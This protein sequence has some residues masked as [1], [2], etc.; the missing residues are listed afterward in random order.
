MIVFYAVRPQLLCGRDM[1]ILV[2][3][4]IQLKA[5]LSLTQIIMFTKKKKFKNAYGTEI[6]HARSIKKRRKGCKGRI[7]RVKNES[8]YNVKKSCKSDVQNPASMINYIQEQKV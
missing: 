1:E 8:V 4:L 3:D 5:I 6:I 2:D 7:M